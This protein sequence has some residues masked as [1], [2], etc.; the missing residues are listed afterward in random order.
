MVATN[1]SPVFSDIPEDAIYYNAVEALAIHGILNGYPDG[2]FGGDKNITRAEM[3]TVAIRAMDLEN[4]VIAPAEQQYTDVPAAHWAA[5]YISLA[6][7]LGIVQGDGGGTFRPNDNVKHEE[8]VKIIVIAMGYGKAAEEAGG[9]PV[10]YTQVAESKGILENTSGVIGENSIRSEIALMTYQGLLSKDIEIE[11]PT[12][13]NGEPSDETEFYYSGDMVLAYSEK[14]PGILYV[15]NDI[16][17]ST[18]DGATMEDV[19]LAISYF[20]GIINR[21]SFGGAYIIGVPISTEEELEEM[22]QYLLDNY[23]DIIFSARV[24]Y[25]DVT[26]GVD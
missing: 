2:T 3:V 10:G 15:C 6:T 4:S 20:D 24:R 8:A 16:S 14:R 19:I 1:A 5:G 26:T 18:Q 21:A 11:E 9:W 13:N 12:D 17:V 23:P 7:Q 25:A 22:C